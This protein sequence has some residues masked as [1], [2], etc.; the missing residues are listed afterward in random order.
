MGSQDHYWLRTSDYRLV[1]TD[2]KGAYRLNWEP[3]YVGV[4]FT[5]G[6]HPEIDKEKWAQE[7]SEKLG[8]EC[9]WIFQPRKPLAEC[10]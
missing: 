9:R 8:I 6:E 10:D 2:Q 7:I 4:E 5:E 1:F 3:G